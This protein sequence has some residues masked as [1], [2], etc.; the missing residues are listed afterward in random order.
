MTKTSVDT[1]DKRVEPLPRLLG[2]YRGELDIALRKALSAQG[3]GVYDMLRYFMGWV[4]VN[5]KPCVATQGKGLRPSLCLFACEATGGPI[6]RGMPAAV[7]LELIHNFS[8]IHDDIQDRD[9]TRHHR[10]TLWAV[11]GDAKAL[12]A[13]NVL[14]LV[15]DMSLKGLLDA[16]VELDTAIAVGR[17]LTEAYLE[18]IEGQYLDMVFE[19]RRDIS[20]D[21]YMDL[22]SRKTGALI[23]CSLNIGALIGTRHKVTVEAFR[24]CGR[25]LGYAFQVRDDILGVW[26]VE[27]ATGKPVGADIRRKKNSFPVVCAMS[28]TRGKDRQRL[29]QVYAMDELGDEQVATVLEIM[30]RAGVPEYAQALAS[31]YCDRALQALAGVDIPRDYRDQ[32]EELARFL[33]VRHH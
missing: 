7:A 23:R 5:G 8:L 33:L 18:M 13:G 15:A 17:L 12:V 30:E 11:W 22:I 32:V 24:E 3:L 9:A 31:Q 16:G 14:R 29:L 4:D 6:S 25:A 28:R 26:G 2:K 27:E 10:P 1:V 20:L 19:G 21:D